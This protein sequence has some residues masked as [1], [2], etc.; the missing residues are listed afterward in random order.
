MKSW[1]FM[2]QSPSAARAAAEA[3]DGGSCSRAPGRNSELSTAEAS[4]T[5]S[6]ESVRSMRAE[7][8]GGL[9]SSVSVG[10]NLGRRCCR[11]MSRDGPSCFMC[12]TRR[13][14]RR[15]SARRAANALDRVQQRQVQHVALRVAAAEPVRHAPAGWRAGVIAS[16]VVAAAERDQRAA[17]RQAELAR[18]L[19]VPRRLRLAAQPA[20]ARGAAPAP[21]RARRRRPASR[22]RR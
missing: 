15:R 13:P 19:A 17:G 20:P 7:P 22:A 16:A 9:S 10:T 3:G 1:L 11:R 12:C 2:M 21:S 6:V 5:T 18:R 8:H 14:R 4:A